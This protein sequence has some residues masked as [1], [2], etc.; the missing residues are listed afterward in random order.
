MSRF[1]ILVAVVLAATLACTVCLAAVIIHRR[2]A[3]PD[4][5]PEEL[6]PYRGRATSLG[7]MSEDVHD[8]P[9]SGR[10]IFE[11]AWPHI[12]KAK[13]EGASLIL[14]NS[15]SSYAGLSELSAGVRILAPVVNLTIGFP[16]GTQV[17]GGP[18]WPDS[19]RTD[20]GTL[21]EYVVVEDGK[22]VPFTEE[23]GTRPTSHRSRA[24]VDIVL[25]VDGK[26]VDLNRIELPSDTPIVDR[27]FKE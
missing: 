15:P 24:R 2:G 9:F 1:I 18:P 13:S 27:R 14:E 12:L 4:S 6:E 3:W 25:V 16:D 8:I 23:D 20:S 26:I 11:K 7:G 17:E 21:P 19:A 22:W 5:W 10:S